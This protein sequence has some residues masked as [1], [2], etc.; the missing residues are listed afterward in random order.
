MLQT[1]RMT[2]TALREAMEQKGFASFRKLADALH[3]NKPKPKDLPAAHSLATYLGKL[4]K[5][6][7]GWFDK[8]EQIFDAICAILEVDRERLLPKQAVSPSL[9]TFDGFPELR[10]LD[11]RT[12]D[13]VNLLDPSL[14][15]IGQVFGIQ[16]PPWT[17]IVDSDSE[18]AP[19]ASWIVAPRGAG[20]RL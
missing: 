4:D 11:L 9:H 8:R 2:Q 1:A 15:S 19:R 17:S 3:R 6:D 10:P 18:N 20:A 14:G 7:V 12:E 13:P 16:P 5:G